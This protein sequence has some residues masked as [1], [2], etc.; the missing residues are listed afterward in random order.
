MFLAIRRWWNGGR[1]KVTARLFMFE[2]VV[3]VAGVLVA[4]A[5]ANWAQQ[6][7]AYASMEEARKRVEIEA[8]SD[9]YA[10][11]IMKV[12]APCLEQRMRE[13]MRQASV[14]PVDAAFA[15]RPSIKSFFLS[16]ISDESLLL[17]RK[18]YG[19]RWVRSLNNFF[20]NN[21]DLDKRTGTIA[22]VWGRIAMASAD[23]G[24]VS[25]GDRLAARAAA[26]EVLAEMRGVRINADNLLKWGAALGL[27]PVPGIEPEFGPA[28]TCSAIWKSG[29]SDPPL[30]LR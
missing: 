15:E 30:S 18:R 28:K 21:A 10:A 16:P 23:N 29:R 3:V 27:K 9:M 22:T 13:I 20:N 11:L 8:S 4:Q 25:P 6:R 26:A 14:G 19:E 5:L 7:A 17:M 24:A 2:F 12:A 1:G